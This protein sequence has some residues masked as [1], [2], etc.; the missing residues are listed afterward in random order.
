MKNNWQKKLEN[1]VRE[2]LS[3]YSAC[4]DFWHHERVKNWALEIAQAVSCDRDVLI[5]AALLHDT[6]YKNFEDDDDNHHLHSMDVARNWL[7]E[8]GFPEEKI[9][10]TL[11]AIKFHDNLAMDKM[12]EIDHIEAKI[13]QDADKLDSLGAIG[14]TRFAYYYGERGHPIYSDKPIPE[15]DQLW[16]DHSLLDQLRRDG[17][18]KWSKLNFPISKELGLSRHKFMENFY[19]ELKKEL[20]SEES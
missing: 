20:Q 19:E 7:P 12:I 18:K 10:D 13:I 3:D 6:G 5:A 8:V 1:K 9:A 15:S 2:Y 11:E 4:H 14:I 16:V 17:L